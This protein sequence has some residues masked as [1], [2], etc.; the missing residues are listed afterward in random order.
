M[1]KS[2]AFSMD[3]LAKL[4]ENY[5]REHYSLV[6]TGAHGSSRVWREGDIGNLSGRQ[7]IDAISRGGLWLN[8]RNVGSV[9]S[10]YRELVDQM[11]AE[12][13]AKVP[14]FDDAAASP[15]RHSD[16]VAGR[17]GLLSRRP[18]RAEPDPDRRPQARL[19]LSEHR[20]VR[21]AGAPRGHRAV[22]CRGRYA[23]HGMVRRPCAGARSRARPD[24]EL[25]A[26]C[27]APRRESRHLQ[28]LDDGLLHQ[29]GNP[30]YPRSST[31]PTACC[32]IASA[33]SRR[34]AIC[35]GRP[36]SPRR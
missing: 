4:I 22:R 2:P 19:H 35:A 28:H 29:R 1:H 27:A 32:A 36:T 31:S 21:H 5:P 33:S 17:A 10:R 25:A 30:A 20:A 12:I 16:L 26:E 13:G 9:D 8:L 15:G 7:V 3:D 11:F 23:L 34:A 14:G 6:Q 24:A 18:A